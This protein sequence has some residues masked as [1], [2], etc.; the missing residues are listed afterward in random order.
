MGALFLFEI[1]PAMTPVMRTSPETPVFTIGERAS[2]TPALEAGKSV[3]KFGPL[4]FGLY[5]GGLAF[6]SPQEAEDHMRSHNWDRAKW[7][8]YE[9][10]GDYAQDTANGHLTNSLLVVKAH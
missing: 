5:P 8:I 3:V 7:A 9:L 4:L 2:Y 10:S 6:A 1:R